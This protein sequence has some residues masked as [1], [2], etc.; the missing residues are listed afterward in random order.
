MYDTYPPDDLAEF[1]PIP[2]A[3]TS[4]VSV[5]TA[6]ALATTKAVVTVCVAERKVVAP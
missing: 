3:T 6:I 2:V 1:G 4:Q 5:P